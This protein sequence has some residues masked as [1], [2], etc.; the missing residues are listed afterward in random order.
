MKSV[1][2]HI[3][4]FIFLFDNQSHVSVELRNAVANQRHLNSSALKMHQSGLRFSKAL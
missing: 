4:L 1:Y 2:L 3:D